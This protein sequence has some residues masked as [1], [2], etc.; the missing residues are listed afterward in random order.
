M[1]MAELDQEVLEVME[2]AE[3]WGALEVCLGHLVNL[4]NYS[5]R[6]EVAKVLDKIEKEVGADSCND[7]R[8]MELFE[9][10]KGRMESLKH[11]T[12]MAATGMEEN[13]RVNSEMV[14]AGEKL[15]RGGRG[16]QM[17]KDS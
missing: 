4:E 14:R 3:G 10:L 2:V 8:E 9:E 12:M 17:G 1:L 15:V 5:K 11:G 7:R 16:G 13:G 6:V